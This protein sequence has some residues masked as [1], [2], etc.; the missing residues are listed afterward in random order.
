M[1]NHLF[2]VFPAQVRGRVANVA[3]EIDE[4]SCEIFDLNAEGVELQ[5]DLVQGSTV[6]LKVGVVG[7]E[8][9]VARTCNGQHSI[10]PNDA[11]VRELGFEALEG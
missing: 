6:P 1:A 7:G 2:A 9:G 4:P 8:F 3:S 10:A 11:E 5:Q